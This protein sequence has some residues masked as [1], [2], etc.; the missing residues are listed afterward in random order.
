[1]SGD[2]SVNQAPITG[3]SMP[4][5][6]QRGDEIFAGSINE[7]GSLEIEVTR[8]S[9]DTTL[10]RI[11]HMVEEA[12]AEKAPSQHFVERFASYYTPLVVT[13]AVLM[14]ALP[15]LL[16]GGAFTTWFYRA[17]VL[18][19]IAC[20][21][22]LVISTPV[23]IV[24]GLTA[25]ARQGILIKGGV[26]LENAGALRVIAFDKTGTLTRGIPSVIGIVSVNGQSAADILRIAAS[27]E[28]RSEHPLA[29]AI[30]RK[31][32]EEGVTI[33]ET[34][35]FQSITGK[36]AKAEIN[37]EIYYIGNHRLFEEKGL[38][39]PEIDARL[40]GFEREGKTA[41]LLGTEREPIGVIAIAD[42]LRQNASEAIQHLRQ[43]GI[44][45]V[46][47]LTGD[48]RGTAQAIAER[49]HIDQFYAEL[50][51][52][53]KVRIMKQL[54]KERSRVAMVGDGVNDA[55]ALAIA[56][57]GIA[58]GTAGT[59][60]ALETADI[61]L[62]ADDLSKLPLAMKLSRKALHIIKQ[63]IVFALLI[64]AVF[65]AMTP[66]G[67]AT[68]WMAV[69]ADMGASLMVIFNGLRVLRFAQ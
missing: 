56:T 37:G 39:T 63:N 40:D 61:A 3:E 64:K 20:P 32:G 68:L 54:L 41:V 6:K 2:S 31:A 53:D 19:V 45:K 65:L 10:A 15:P 18:L 8:R 26:Y 29:E 23:T 13:T 50:L 60:T 62:M 42:E 66:I 33:E 59:D 30:L 35:D 67:W 14:A 57:I 47:M 36:G 34:G 48:N 55:P 24:S 11:V 43:N 17:L 38:C 4:V 46:V 69:F 58:M 1:V 27:V 44:K 7:K 16:L 25:A 49:L 5:R 21:C 22:A 12:Q 51:P 9:Q 52:E 28:S